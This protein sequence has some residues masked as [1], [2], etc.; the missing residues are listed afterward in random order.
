VEAVVRM[1]DE[2][3]T[4]DEVLGAYP[5]LERDDIGQALSGIEHV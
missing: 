4:A 2:G 1:L 5:D 3:M